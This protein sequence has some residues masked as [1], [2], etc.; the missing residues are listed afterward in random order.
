MK[1]EAGMKISIPAIA[2]AT[3]PLMPKLIARS[4]PHAAVASKAA[5]AADLAS[6]RL[7]PHELHLSLLIATTFES[8][9]IATFLHAGQIS[10]LIEVTHND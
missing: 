6:R 10:L 8:L 3:Y 5:I 7:L 1:Y 9:V 4:S 2:K